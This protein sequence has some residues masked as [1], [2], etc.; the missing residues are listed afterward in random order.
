MDLLLNRRPSASEER[1]KNVENEEAKKVVSEEE[2]NR[3]IESIKFF[4]VS[5]FAVLS[6]EENQKTFVSLK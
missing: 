5:V 2:K 6:Q 3:I 1:C 4:S